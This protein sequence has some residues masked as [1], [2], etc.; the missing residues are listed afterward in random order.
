MPALALPHLPIPPLW[1]APL[2]LALLAYDA[3][4]L[5]GAWW[6]LRRWRAARARRAQY[7]PA[8]AQPRLVGSL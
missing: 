4:L 5:Y 7:P 6:L 2:L 1:W 3:A 8:L